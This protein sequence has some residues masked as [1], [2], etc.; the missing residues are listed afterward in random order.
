MT[1]LAL[2]LCLPTRDSP[3]M[4]DTSRAYRPWTRDEDAQISW[5]WGDKAAEKVAE[6]VGRTPESVRRRFRRMGMSAAARRGRLTIAQLSRMSG[7]HPR[8]IHRA[9]EGSGKRVSRSSSKPGALHL[10]TEEQAGEIIDWLGQETRQACED[11]TRT[12]G[13]VAAEHDLPRRTAYHVAK[14][15]GIRPGKLGPL[16]QRRLVEAMTR[17]EAA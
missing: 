5:A 12:I 1:Q 7:Y 8:D 9:I 15:I 6:S 13:E 10:L 3:P 2:P 11:Q 14:R 4:S 17:R 16:D